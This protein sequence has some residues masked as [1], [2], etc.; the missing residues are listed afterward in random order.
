MSKI[1]VELNSGAV[2]ELL[3][4]SEMAAACKA[5]ADAIAKR[6]G[7]GYSSDSYTGKNRVNAMVYPESNAAKEDNSE[8]NTLLRSLK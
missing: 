5:E 8:N 6:C 2:R 7:A 3:K 1:R 4:S